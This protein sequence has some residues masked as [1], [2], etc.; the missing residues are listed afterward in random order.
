M[1]RRIF[2][3]FI[4]MP[5]ALVIVALAVANR[6]AVTVSF[7]PFSSIN[8]AFALTLPLYLLAFFLLICG[9]VIGGIAAWLRQR[10]WRR[11]ARSREA[12]ARALQAEIDALR[13]RFGLG[14]RTTLPATLNHTPQA[15][16]RSPAA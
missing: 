3:L 16:L 11:A 15:V 9:V 12:E 4:L 13:R 2:V 14:P 10:R 7:D 5:L 6:Q 1:V 8:P